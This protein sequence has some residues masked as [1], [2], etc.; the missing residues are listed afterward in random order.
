M[1][2]APINSDEWVTVQAHGDRI[3]SD[4][5]KEMD[6]LYMER[7]E[8]GRVI[9]RSEFNIDRRLLACAIIRRQ[10]ELNIDPMSSRRYPPDAPK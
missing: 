6:S 7:T 9:D 2:N 1:E 3:L 8:P 5:M 10:I 4:W